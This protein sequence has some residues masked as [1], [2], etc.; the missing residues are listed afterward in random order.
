M[1]WLRAAATCAPDVQR[2]QSRG[3]QEQKP[4]KVIQSAIKS[5]IEES[6]RNNLPL[7][8]REDS[9]PDRLAAR[10]SLS[11]RAPDFGKQVSERD[12]AGEPEEHRQRLGDEDGV[13]VRCGGEGEGGDD[14][15]GD[16]E[17]GPDGG[18]YEKVDF[19]GGIP[20]GCD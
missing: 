19:R 18:E 2:R 3:S 20:V 7:K 14:E 9:T 8:G 6:I 1:R 17:E 11:R 4:A 5:I 13:L 10:L 12:E 16:G 15:V